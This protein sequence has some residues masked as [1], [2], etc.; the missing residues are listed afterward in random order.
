M[1]CYFRIAP[2]F[3]VKVMLAAAARRGSNE[4]AGEHAALRQPAGEAAEGQEKAK[5]KLRSMAKD[6][7]E[8][9]GCALQE[10]YRTSVFDIPLSEGDSSVVS[11]H[12]GARLAAA[13]AMITAHLNHCAICDTA[14][15]YANQS[16]VSNFVATGG[17]DGSLESKT[18]LRFGELLL[19]G[20]YS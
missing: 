6:Q 10:D 20:N 18:R 4:A 2:P 11:N 12:R 1:R 5:R 17:F 7:M 3:L 13:A 19:E 16:S 14:V 9:R 15:A 8:K